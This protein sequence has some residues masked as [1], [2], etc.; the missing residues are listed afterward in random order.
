MVRK[1][2]VIELMINMSRVIEDKIVTLEVE[3][4]SSIANIN[5]L[6]PSAANM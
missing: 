5:P 4:S 1:S 3:L 2:W 6:L